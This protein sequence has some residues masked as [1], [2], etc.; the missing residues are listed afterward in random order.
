M[1]VLTAKDAAT[2]IPAALRHRDRTGA[3]PAVEAAP[4]SS[5]LASPVDQAS[6]HLATGRAPGPIGDRHPS[7]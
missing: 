7:G 6:A 5:L 1:D 4:L 3:G 2:G